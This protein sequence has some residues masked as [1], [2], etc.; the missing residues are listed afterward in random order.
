MPRTVDQILREI[1]GAYVTSV[2]G[3]R[4]GKYAGFHRGTDFGGYGCG[5]EFKSPVYGK[6]VTAATSGMGA[7][8][9][10]VEIHFNPYDKSK[11]PTHALVTGHHLKLLVKRGQW[12]NKGDIIA[13]VGGSS[14][15]TG[16]LYHYS[17]H[18][19]LEI[20]KLDGNSLWRRELIDPQKFYINQTSPVEK[21]DR[22]AAG[23]M[24]VNY[25]TRNVIIRSEPGIGSLMTGR[26]VKPG[27]QVEVKEHEDNGIHRTSY[28]WW[29]IGEGWVAEDFFDKNIPEPDPE[30]I[31]P[32]ELEED[33]DLPY[34]PTEEEEKQTDFDLRMLQL[35]S[36]L[37]K[38]IQKLLGRRL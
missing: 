8:G 1:S 29:F 35:F 26:F 18:V 20:H 30:P 24:I 2:Y 37:P 33:S 16:N 25:I 21:S 31:V 4:T 12:V 27:E 11:E 7:N 3:P 5:G 19:H 34:E 36:R 14:H 17:C 28:H 38:L 32:P 13:T 6:V 10:T 22:F 23:D 9:H 15:R